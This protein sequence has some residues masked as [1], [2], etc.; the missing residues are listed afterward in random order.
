MRVAFPPKVPGPVA[1]AGGIDEGG[2]DLVIDV[3]VLL[4]GDAAEQIAAPGLERLDPAFNCIAITADAV[5]WK[6]A[7]PAVARDTVHRGAAPLWFGLVP[8]QERGGDLVVPIGKYVD[9]DSDEI[10]D[11]PF[12]SEAATIDFG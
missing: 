12:D 4:R 10:A 5:H 2:A 11:D 7:A 9:F 6:L 3:H 1:E 8:I